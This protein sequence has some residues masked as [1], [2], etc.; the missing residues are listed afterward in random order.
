VDRSPRLVN[1]TATG[2]PANLVEILEFVAQGDGNS[3]GPQS[4][5]LPAAHG[6]QGDRAHDAV[7]ADDTKPGKTPGFF[8]CQGGHDEAHL[9]GRGPQVPGDG[10]VSR[11]SSFRDRCHS[12]QDARFKSQY[13]ARFRGNARRLSFWC[14]ECHPQFLRRVLALV[15]TP[16]SG[17]PQAG[18]DQ[19]SVPPVF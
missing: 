7:G 17:L 4:R 5:D 16:D 18:L 3:L 9:A 2:R 15:Q 14:Q 8:A 13:F 19:D 11:H 10:A 6:S 1:R 12:G